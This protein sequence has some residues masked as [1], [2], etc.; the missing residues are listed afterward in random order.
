MMP[1]NHCISAVQRRWMNCVIG[2]W[3][4]MEHGKTFYISAAFILHHDM[5]GKQKIQLYNVD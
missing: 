3:A 2:R 5:Y 4:M 1:L